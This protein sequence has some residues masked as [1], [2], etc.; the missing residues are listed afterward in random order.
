MSR[1]LLDLEHDDVIK[2]ARFQL[3]RCHGAA[4][5]AEWAMRW[6]RALCARAE[7]AA[8]LE[9]DMEDM[10]PKHDLNKANEAF[11]KTFDAL[12]ALRRVADRAANELSRELEAAEDEERPLERAF[13]LWVMEDLDGAVEAAKQAERKI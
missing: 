7:I 6:G 1:T 4:Q 2:D 5:H 12:Q 10:V 11:D 9:R 3:E 13:V 8:D